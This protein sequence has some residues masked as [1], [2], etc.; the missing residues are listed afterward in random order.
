MVKE[1]EVMSK[2]R[3]RVTTQKADRVQREVYTVSIR[4]FV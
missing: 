3:Y 1:I 4:I 2:L